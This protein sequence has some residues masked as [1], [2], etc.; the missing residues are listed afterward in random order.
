MKLT[1]VI[2]SANDNP[3]YLDYWPYVSIAWRELIG[4]EPVLFYIGDKK[5]VESLSQ[6]GQVINVGVS[7]NWDIVNQSQ[8]VRL[9]AGTIF[10]DEYMIISD[11]DMLPISGDYYINSVKEVADDCL[12]SYTSDVLNYGFYLRHPQLPMC[13][14]AGKGS[15]FNEILGLNVGFTWEDFMNQLKSSDSGYGTDQKYFWK[16]FLSWKTEDRYVGL[17]RGWIDGKIATNRLDKVKWPEGDYNIGLYYD[18]HLP[19]PLK[20]NFSRCKQLFDKLK[21]DPENYNLPEMDIRRSRITREMA[22]IVPLVDPQKTTRKVEEK[23]EGKVD[24]IQINETR[25]LRN[26][27]SSM[28]GKKSPDCL[29]EST[30]ITFYS[31]FF[32][33]GYY[34][35]FAEEFESRCKAFGVNYII[36]ELKSRESYQLNCLMKP[37]FILE[38]VMNLKRS[39]IWMDCDTHWIAPF[40]AFNNLSEDIG[41]ATHSGDLNG[42]KASPLFFNY[43]PGSFRILREWTL[44]CFNCVEDGVPE[45]DHD[46][47]KHYVLPSLNGKFD[48]FLLSNGWMDYCDGQFIKNGNSF[49]PGKREIHRKA[50]EYGDSNRFASSKKYLNV[51]LEMDVSCEKDLD[52]LYSYLLNMYNCVRV[53]F[54]I[55]TNMDLESNETYKKILI[56]SGGK[57]RV[58]CS[59]DKNIY[60]TIIQVKQKALLNWDLFIYNKIKNGNGNN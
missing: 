33:G 11:I 16:K 32:E 53:D 43:T 55:K 14:L 51:C 50:M 24:R 47:I 2:L 23:V 57:V 31:D 3:T 8:S 27:I 44:H 25:H 40:T 34:K 30:I 1:K 7:D 42:I 35:K 48:I 26:I 17:N 10:P 37:G 36:D 28:S 22:R 12:V 39:I 9:W 4:I 46:A 20:E 52:I 45:L 38:K 49:V 41:M 13:Y 5:K 6:Y 29:L 18:S 56:E 15:T 21:L 19:I 58:N 60:H 54:N 59:D